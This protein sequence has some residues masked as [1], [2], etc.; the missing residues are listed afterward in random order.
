MPCIHVVAAIW[1]AIEH[2]EHYAAECFT[3]VSFLKAYPWP[4]EP[5]N[6][7]QQWPTSNYPPIEAP[8]V[9]KL[10]HRPTVKKKPS[11]GEIDRVK[12]SKKGLVQR[13]SHCNQEG[14]NKIKCQNPP[15]QG[16]FDTTINLSQAI[17]AHEQG[18]TQVGP[19]QHKQKKQQPK[20]KLANP[21]TQPA[22]LSVSMHNKGVR[23][24][25]YPNGFQKPAQ[26]SYLFLRILY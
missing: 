19:S 12:A 15:K 7:P 2:P 6:G 20:K 17:P 4:L 5:L 22:H 18:H 9:E 16:H 23:I 26:M 8:V 21:S 3:N 11:I 24:Y 14:H 1:K 10:Q 25:T 13:C